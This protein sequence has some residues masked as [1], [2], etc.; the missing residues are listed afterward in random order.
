[1]TIQKLPSEIKEKKSQ[2]EQQWACSKPIG[3]DQPSVIVKAS[4]LVLLTLLH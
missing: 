2:V 4:I 1:M 3:R